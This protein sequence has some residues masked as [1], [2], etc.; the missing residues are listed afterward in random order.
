MDPKRSMAAGGVDLLEPFAAQSTDFLADTD[1][2][3]VG[4][5]N[6]RI[7]GTDPEDPDSTPGDS[8]V[9][10]LVY[11]SQG[12]LDR[13]DGEPAAR[14]RHYLSL[15]NATLR[16]SD[17][18]LRFRQVGMVLVS[19]GIEWGGTDEPTTEA[20]LRENAR[21]GAD[22]PLTLNAR[23]A[24]VFGNCGRAFLGGWN[25]S[26][27]LDAE[28]FTTAYA[29]V[30]DDD[31]CSSSRVTVHELG[32]LMGLA[33]SYAQN[34]EGF[35]FRWSRGYRIDGDFHTTMAYRS[36]SARQLDVFS[37][38]DATCRGSANT[39][40]PCGVDRDQ[41]DGADARTSL[42]VTRFQVAALREPR[43]SRLRSRASTTTAIRRA[44]A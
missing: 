28:V 21:H 24:P 13:Y 19:P 18:P 5:A 22:L 23:D 29:T 35:A 41:A 36:G 38:P 4:D 16:D 27:G 31:R 20:F 42:D 11:Y 34:E 9:D 37:S 3:G 10:V 15:A 6:E 30:F 26:G 44:A 2:D 1:G 14:I 8:T 39:D 7:A 40:R 43:P 33:H 17:I 25:G 12:F 32:H